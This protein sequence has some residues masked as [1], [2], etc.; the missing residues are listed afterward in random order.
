MNALEIEK[1]EHLEDMRNF[2]AASM[3]LFSM[4][5]RTFDLGSEITI[6]NNFEIPSTYRDIFKIRKNHS[7]FDLLKLLFTF[8]IN[9]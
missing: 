7:M 2:Y 1:I 4:L 3:I 8:K 6:A 5:N 9:V